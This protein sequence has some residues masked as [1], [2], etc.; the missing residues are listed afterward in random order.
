MSECYSTLSRRDILQM[1]L[2]IPFLALQEQQKDYVYSHPVGLRGAGVVVSESAILYAKPSSDSEILDEFPYNARAQI[3]GSRSGFCRVQTTNSE[4]GYFDQTNFVRTENAPHL[5]V[6][7][8]LGEG[9]GEIDILNNRGHLKRIFEPSQVQ[10]L[11]NLKGIDIWMGY[12]TDVSLGST[13]NG[14]YYGFSEPP[15]CQ[16]YADLYLYNQPGDYGARINVNPCVGIVMLF[17]S[18]MTPETLYA[19]PFTKERILHPNADKNGNW[20]GSHPEG[21]FAVLRSE[22]SF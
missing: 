16:R 5:S 10:N 17:E 22:L 7:A 14:V 9:I 8:P 1:T 3:L 18:E 11:Y 6:L 13:G 4:T 2:A 21:G 12:P 20:Y 19:L 15:E